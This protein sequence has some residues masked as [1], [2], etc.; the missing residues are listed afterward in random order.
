M[1]NV[2]LQRLKDHIGKELSDSPSPFGSWLK[3]TVR[4]VEIGSLTIEFTVRKEMTNPAHILHGGATA[5][6][7]DDVMGMTVASLGHDSFFATVNLSIDYLSSAKVGDIITATS[8]INREGKHIV[9]I[10]CVIVNQD[11]KILSKATSN[12]FKTMIPK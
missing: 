2:V 9:N 11:G 12:L 10:D 7:M 5:A 1:E 4:A 6:I 8:K 3:G